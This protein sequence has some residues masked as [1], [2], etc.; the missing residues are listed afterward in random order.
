MTLQQL[1]YFCVMT[2]VLHYTKAAD[3]LYI[4]QP[5]LSYA[6]SELEKE[7]GVPLFEKRG[8]QTFLTKF[9]AEFLPFAKNALAQL[10]AGEAKLLEMSNPTGGQINLGYIYSVG[11]TTMPNLVESF[12]LHQGNRQIN[13][14]FQQ[15]MTQVLIERL[16]E[17][18]LDL[19]LSSD[20]VNENITAAPFYQQ[21]LFLIVYDKHPLAQRKSV[22]MEELSGEDLISINHN[23]SLFRLIEDSLKNASV[24]P[25]FLFEVDECNSIAAFVNSGV[26]IAVMPKIP[27]LDSYAV[28]AIPFEGGM[29]RDISL[30]WV[31]DRHML[32]AVQCFVDYVTKVY[33]KKD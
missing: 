9:G 2:E 6:L 28:K 5:S 22:R 20:P 7:L 21:E 3:Q 23:T 17:G 33:N 14:N 30:L 11:T 25:Q 27:L 16:L 26:G 15:S 18:S 24:K 19:L 10:S 13:F 12:Y 31:K 1:R 4:S 32:P 29:K 8:R